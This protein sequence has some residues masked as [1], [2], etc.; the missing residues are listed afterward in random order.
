LNKRQSKSHKASC[1]KGAAE[2]TL[3]TQVPT[4]FVGYISS[5]D[6]ALYEKLRHDDF[7][8]DIA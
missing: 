6:Y 7:E 5:S 4:A 8:Q 1:Y 3:S 2:V